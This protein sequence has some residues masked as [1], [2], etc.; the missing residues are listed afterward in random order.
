MMFK[1][2]LILTF[3]VFAS[4]GAV[5]EGP[6]GQRDKIIEWLAGEYREEP[7]ASGISSKGALIEVLSTDDGG[8]WSILL[9]SPNGI[10]CIV[11]DGQSWQP[12]PHEFKTAEPKT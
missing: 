10:S 5:A 6:C 4:S 2:V 3:M 7:I 11:D 9:T 1:V 8:S 12:K